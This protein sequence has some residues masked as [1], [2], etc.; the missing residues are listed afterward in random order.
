MIR[1]GILGLDSTHAIEFT[2]LLAEPGSSRPAARVIG[3]CRGSPTD[4]PLSRQRAERIERQWRD[5]LRLPVF[6]SPAALVAASDALMVLTCD[7]R[8]RWFEVEPLLLARKPLFIDKPLSADWRD[9]TRIISAADRLGCPCFSA[10]ALRYRLDAAAQAALSTERPLRLTIATPAL[11]EVGH[12]DL[13]WHGIHAVEAAYAL[14]GPGCRTVAR[15]STPE[16]DITHGVWPDG[17]SVA[18][19]RQAHPT[20]GTFP[21]SACWATG[22][23]GLSGHD[24]RPLLEA[25]AHFF[26]TGIAPVSSHEMT[27][28]LGFIAAADASRDA[29]GTTIPLSQFLHTPAGA[30]P[31][32]PPAPERAPVP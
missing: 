17:S 23:M 22:E 6:H 9:G 27:E 5:E 24:Y 13:S 10:S 30:A 32:P 15:E 4:F 8:T 3:A 28:V 21:L 19:E 25:I 16:R 7:G 14:L 2:R 20:A 31:C 18:I 29:G 11:S 1:I 12:P 26:A